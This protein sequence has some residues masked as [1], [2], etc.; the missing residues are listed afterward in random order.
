MPVEISLSF[1]DVGYRSDLTSLEQ[2][3]LFLSEN[4]RGKSL[5]VL[6]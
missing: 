6:S 5:S 1:W 3:V 4:L 2:G